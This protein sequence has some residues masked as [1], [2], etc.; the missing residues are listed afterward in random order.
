MGQGWLSV[1]EGLAFRCV[2]VG[3]GWGLDRP[4]DV[5]AWL[6]LSVHGHIGTLA[7]HPEGRDQHQTIEPENKIQPGSNWQIFKKALKWDPVI[8][9]ERK[10]QRS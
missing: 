1:L 5:A 8:L 4:G 9:A 2:A 10:E 6:V 3:H 7:F